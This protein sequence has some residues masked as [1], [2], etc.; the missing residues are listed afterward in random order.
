M[1]ATEKFLGEFLNPVPPS[2]EFL[3]LNFS[4]AARDRFDRWRNYGLSADF[5]GDY[6]SAFFS[7]DVASSN[8]INQRDQ[9]KG[10]VGYIANELLE[11]AVK[12]SD[13]TLNLPV[14]I[15]LRLYDDK[16]IFEASN[17]TDLKSAKHYQDFIETLLA[18]DANELFLEQLEKTAT[19]SGV[20]NIGLLTMINDYDAKFGWKFSPIPQQIDVFWVTVMVHL[21]V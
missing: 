17:P 19:G 3:S 8:D 2:D 7:G 20:S 13:I 18:R 21:Q 16:I 6:F 11:N 14:N 5:L 10:S 4:L 12:Y 15:T 9:V 1:T